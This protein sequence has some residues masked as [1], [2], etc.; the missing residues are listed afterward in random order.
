[1]IIEGLY[2]E[3]YTQDMEKSYGNLNQKAE[4]KQVLKKKQTLKKIKFKMFAKLHYPP[5]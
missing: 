2:L 1:M 5:D 4:T 3:L